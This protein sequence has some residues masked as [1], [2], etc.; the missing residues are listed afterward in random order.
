MMAPIAGPI[1]TGRAI[2]RALGDAA[3]VAIL[4]YVV[5]LIIDKLIA[6]ELM[7]RD[8]SRRLDA[9]LAIMAHAI[10]QERQAATIDMS[11]S[12]ANEGTQS[13]PGADM[14]AAPGASPGAASDFEPRF[15]ARA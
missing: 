1:A 8:Q 9:A 3:A 5:A 6:I 10:E 7:Q 2:G 13:G 11:A 4:V 15:Y 14:D 12:A